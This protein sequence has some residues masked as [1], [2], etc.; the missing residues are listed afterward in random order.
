MLC[1]GIEALVQSA[2]LN[3]ATHVRVTPISVKD[4]KATQGAAIEI[5]RE[6][7]LLVSLPFLL[8]R[9]PPPVDTNKVALYPPVCRARWYA[10]MCLLRLLPLPVGYALRAVGACRLLDAAE[11]RARAHSPIQS[12]HVYNCKLCARAGSLEHH[13]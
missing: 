7:W 1:A 12:S 2:A 9:I 3:E 8:A 4:G 11:V 5:A 6:D 13:S 10:R